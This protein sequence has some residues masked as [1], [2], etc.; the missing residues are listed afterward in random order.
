M[1]VVPFLAILK[2][3]FLKAQDLKYGMIKDIYY[4]IFFGIYLY[5]WL[6]AFCWLE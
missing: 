2:I 1:E 6:Q 3:Y 4:S 5:Y